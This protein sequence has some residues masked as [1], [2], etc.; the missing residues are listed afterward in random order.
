MHNFI[1]SGDYMIFHQPL[2][3][4]S[5][6]NFNTAFYTD[7]VWDFH[8]HKN[9]ELIYVIKGAV[10]C[11]I[12]NVFYRLGEGDFGLC[13][14][15]DIHKYVP[16]HDSKYWVLVFSE[17]FV[18]SFSKLISGKKSDGFVF[19]PSGAVKEYVKAQ[20]IENPNPSNF[21]LK[22]CLYGLCEEFLKNVNLT[23]GRSS[24]AE[25]VSSIVDYVT[26]NHTKKITLSDIAK[27]F[28]YDY[29]YMS[30]FFKSVFNITFTDFL[31]IYRLQTAI[32]LLDYTDKSITEVAYESGF[33]SLRSFHNF[34]SK[35]MDTSPMQ[36]K[37]ASQK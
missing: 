26:E 4:L 29:N 32:E 24:K 6:Y 14:P 28:G 20:L 37:K 3:S 35:M 5:H 17:D 21:T 13:L 8:F 33:Q 31:N 10:N 25:M 15:Y 23:K 7:T 2:N 34:F 30:R 22:S 18:H 9:L 36:Y 27:E 1:F 12:N 11:T 19:T 16:E